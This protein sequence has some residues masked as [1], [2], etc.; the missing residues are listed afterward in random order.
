MDEKEYERRAGELFHRVLDLFDEVDPDVA[1][2]EHSG[3]VITIEFVG[4][5]RVV[6]NT[7]RPARQIWLAGG[8]QAWHFSFDEA[9]GR[10]ID[11]RNGDDELMLVLRKLGTEA[12]VQLPG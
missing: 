12:G 6:L 1:D 8:R 2:V 4:R 5:G 9:S 11:D 10:W 7:Q 3:D